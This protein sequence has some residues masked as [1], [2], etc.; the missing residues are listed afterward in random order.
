MTTVYL[1]G[2]YRRVAG[3]ES[4]MWAVDLGRNNFLPQFDTVSAKGG[5]WRTGC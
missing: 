4:K 5:S 1:T 3:R 2:L